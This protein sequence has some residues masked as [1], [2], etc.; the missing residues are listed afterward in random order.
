MTETKLPKVL[1]DP[2][3]PQGH[4]AYWVTEIFQFKLTAEC[5]NKNSQKSVFTQELWALF[6]SS[7]RKN[8]LNHQQQQNK[9]ALPPKECLKLFE[10]KMKILSN[11][12]QIS[13]GF[14]EQIF[15]NCQKRAA[16]SQQMLALIHLLESSMAWQMSTFYQCKSCALLTQLSS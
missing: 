11:I 10:M 7:Q 13:E 15:L 3:T 5:F 2:P 16:T 1:C 12:F 8:C 6:S 14:H 4:R 9:T